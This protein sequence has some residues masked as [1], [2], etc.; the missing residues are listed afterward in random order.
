MACVQTQRP[1]LVKISSE[2]VTPTSAKYCVVHYFHIQFLIIFV[3][4]GSNAIMVVDSMQLLFAGRY[5]S[6]FAAAI[7]SYIGVGLRV[8]DLTNLLLCSCFVVCRYGTSMFACIIF[9][10]SEG[11]HRLLLADNDATMMVDSTIIQFLF[12]GTAILCLLLLSGITFVWL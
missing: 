10:F 12:A 7:W 4:N 5:D 2:E 8:N 1:A 6:V 11:S 9:I 3:V